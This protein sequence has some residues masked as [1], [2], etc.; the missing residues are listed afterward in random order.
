MIRRCILGAAVLGLLA[1]CGSGGLPLSG[2]VTRGG[3]PLAGVIAF[4]PD[5]SAGTTG[6]G[7]V[8]AI[9]DGKFAVG[10][11]RQIKPGKYVVRISPVPLGSGT[12]LKTAPPQFKP[13]ETAIE[14]TSAEP[15]TFDVP[16]K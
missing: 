1:G 5:A 3:Q 4:E 8:S 15:L 6:A 2:T 11:E 9:R 14:I 16:V 12:D 10:A 13:W 7:A